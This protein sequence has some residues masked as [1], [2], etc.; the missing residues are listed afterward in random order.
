MGFYFAILDTVKNKKVN[1][2]IGILFDVGSASVGA[3]LVAFTPG[4]KP[5][6]LYTTRKDIAI[7][8]KTSAE[9]LFFAMRESFHKAGEDLQRKGLPILKDLGFQQVQIDHVYTVF[10]SVWYISQTKNI[11]AEFDEPKKITAQYI[12]ERVKE[13]E[14]DFVNSSLGAYVEQQEEDFYLLEHN[15]LQIKLNGYDIAEPHGKEA[16]DFEMSLFISMIPDVVAR[17]AIDTVSNLFHT[18]SLHMHSFA[19]SSFSTLRNIFVHDQDFMFLDVAGEVT[20]VGLVKDGA[21]VESASFP[22][23]RNALVREIARKHHTTEEEALSRLWRFARA[24]QNGTEEDSPMYSTMQ[25]LKTKWNR[26]LERM[27][28]LFEKTYP[29]PS[30]IFFFSDEQMERIVHWMIRGDR[31]APTAINSTV[32]GRYVNHHPDADKDAFIE[33]ESLFFNTN[34]TDYQ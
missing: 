19:L 6:I 23:G 18:E 13:E 20:D 11:Q 28:E 27:V 24:I 21:L 3:G 29:A 15:V 31:Y 12:E 9:R 16:S 7:S 1:P 33:I 22:M 5:H 2:E 8:P 34:H 4:E 14:N 30:K 26:E 25:E 32:L 10:S 17:I